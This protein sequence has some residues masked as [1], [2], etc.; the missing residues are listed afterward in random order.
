MGNAKFCEALKAD[1]ELFKVQHSQQNFHWQ[2]AACVGVLVLIAVITIAWYLFLT[3]QQ[4]KQELQVRLGRYEAMMEAKNE[5]IQQLES[6]VQR[7]KNQS[8]Q[9]Q[10][11]QHQQPTVQYQPMAGQTTPFIFA[12]PGRI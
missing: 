4:A 6:S 8:P 5:R 1:L 10:Q 3:M 7:Q 11:Q 2:V 12:F 9:Q